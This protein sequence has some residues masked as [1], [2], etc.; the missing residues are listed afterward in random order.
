MTIVPVK[1]TNKNNNSPCQINGNIPC[2]LMATVSLKLMTISPVKL[3][4]MA[5][6]TLYNI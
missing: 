1:L 4:E 5:I 2:K 6:R 3:I